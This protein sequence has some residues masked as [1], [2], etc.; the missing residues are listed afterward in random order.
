MEFTHDDRELVVD[1]LRENLPLYEDRIT[2]IDGCYY[3]RIW[4]MV[5]DE[6]H[7]FFIDMRDENWRRD[8]V[9]GRQVYI[10]CGEEKIKITLTLVQR[11]FM[12]STMRGLKI[13][14]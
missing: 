8:I 9:K 4:L 2:I 10:V 13:N 3:L 5:N 12:R 1:I 11:I 6:K 14:R 7:T